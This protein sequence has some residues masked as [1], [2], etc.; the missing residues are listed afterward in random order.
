MLI[1]NL[2]K[3]QTLLAVVRHQLVEVEQVR[4]NQPPALPGA[5]IRPHGGREVV[6]KLN[7]VLLLRRQCL[8][9]RAVSQCGRR[10]SIL[11]GTTGPTIVTVDLIF[12]PPSHQLGHY[13]IGR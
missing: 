4:Q 11:V 1:H 10:P 12:K 6:I 7:L 13:D 2:R 8:E 5:K 9:P 3:A